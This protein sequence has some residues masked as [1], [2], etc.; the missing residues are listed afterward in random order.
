MRG[1][2]ESR[3]RDTRKD[4]GCPRTRGHTAA[5]QGETLGRGPE[6]ACLVSLASPPA[7]LLWHPLPGQGLAGATSTT[8][9]QHKLHSEPSPA[10]R[11]LCGRGQVSPRGNASSLRVTS[12]GTVPVG[13]PAASEARSLHVE[14]RVQVCLPCDFP[15]K[16]G[17]CFLKAG[18]LLGGAPGIPSAPCGE[19]DGSSPDPRL[20]HGAWLERSSPWFNA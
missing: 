1:G 6:E 7:G 12:E 3:C 4:P 9:P 16:L 14:G 5:P 13:A 20:S 15:R 8:R 2:L 10:S 11:R 18:I 17:S 19:K